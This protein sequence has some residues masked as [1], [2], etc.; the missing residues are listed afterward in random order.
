MIL[1]LNASHQ[2]KLEKFLME[3]K[4]LNLFI[5]GDLENFGFNEEFIE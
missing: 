2:N 3:E 4:E 5:I 1:K